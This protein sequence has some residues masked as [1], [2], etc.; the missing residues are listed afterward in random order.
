[1]VHGFVV[2]RLLTNPRILPLKTRSGTPAATHQQQSNSSDTTHSHLHLHNTHI[3]IHI[4]IHRARQHTKTET[5]DTDELNSE[6]NEKR[7]RQRESRVNSGV[8]KKNPVTN[9]DTKKKNTP[10][11]YLDDPAETSDVSSMQKTDATLH[12]SSAF[13]QLQQLWIK[14][15]PP[16]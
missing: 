6:G 16:V 14:M 1:M 7:R 12:R 5:G 11:H 10:H 3:H 4:N 2:V 13:P 15:S 8:E 9:I